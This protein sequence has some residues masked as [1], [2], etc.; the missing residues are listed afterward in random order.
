[1]YGSGSSIVSYLMVVSDYNNHIK[2]T[3]TK[4]IS[5]TNQRAWLYYM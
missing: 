4:A 1:M 5:F 3:Y 2:Y